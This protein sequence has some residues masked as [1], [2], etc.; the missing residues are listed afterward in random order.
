MTTTLCAKNL[1]D[2]IK[3]LGLYDF[4]HKYLSDGGTYELEYLKIGGELEATEVVRWLKFQMAVH[5]LLGAVESLR[6]TTKKEFQAI[7]F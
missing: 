5:F 1:V 3:D 6:E 7:K 4:T 2:D